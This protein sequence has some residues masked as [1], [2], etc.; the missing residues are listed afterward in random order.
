MSS[1][2]VSKRDRLHLRLDA[3][4]KRI[5]ER[6]AA[7]TLVTVSQFVMT[8][9]LKAAEAVVASQEQ[10]GMSDRDWEVF[11]RAIEEPPEP[12]AA[13]RVAAKVYAE[14]HGAA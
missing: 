11:L 10:H 13:L 14:H 12:N 4:S 9:A 6:A 1:E 5:L 7:Y 2:S 8:H 3:G